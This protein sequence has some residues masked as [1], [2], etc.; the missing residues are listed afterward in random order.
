[1]YRFALSVLDHPIAHVY[2]R[3]ISNF[4]QHFLASRGDASRPQN[5]TLNRGGTTGI[6]CHSSPSIVI[7]IL[8]KREVIENPC[9]PFSSPDDDFTVHIGDR[10]VT[11]SASWLMSV[12]PVIK[13]ML[14]V[15]M[16]EKRERTLN[17]DGHDITMEQFIQ[18]LETIND[19]LRHGRTLP[20]PT[21][22]LV[23]LKLADYFQIDWLKERCEAHLINCVEIPLIER[24]L[25]I[26]RYRLNY[27]KAGHLKFGAAVLARATIT[28][29]R[30]ETTGIGCINSTTIVI[31]I[32]KKR[33]VIENPC[34][35]LNSPDDDFTVH[36]GDRQVTVS[37]HW[38]M[39][40]SPVVK[41]MLSV[42]M[43]EK[44]QRTLNLDG[45]DITMEQFMQFLESISFNALHGR[46][47]PNPTNVLVLLELADYFQIDWLK[48][49]CEAHLIN[50]VEIPLIERFLLIE[51]YR[52]NILK[53][54][55][56]RRLNA[57]K[58][59]EFLR[60]NHEQLLA[61]ISKELWVELAMRQ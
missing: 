29:N 55:F 60:A 51:R 11:V 44:Q 20:N 12:S 30:G 32:L 58:L 4:T 33:E 56:L 57:D 38:L 43:K 13:R 3:V 46:T 31:R 17:L 37:A 26:E 40:V 41:R 47:L 1:M 5:I 21:N 53:N 15:E 16:K 39:V 49:R 52:L 14:S 18:F 8:Q 61:S 36:I 48:E 35:P 7:R 28:L 24:F 10:Q 23:L 50:C 34:P 45:H 2:C 22:V 54:F 19:H 27:L 25:L 59:R 9:P 6:G 42:E